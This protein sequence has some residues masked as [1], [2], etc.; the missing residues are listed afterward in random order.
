MTFGLIGEIL[1]DTGHLVGL[2]IDY[3]YWQARASGLSEGDIRAALTVVSGLY[4]CLALSLVLPEARVPSTSAAAMAFLLPRIEAAG[5]WIGRQGW[6]HAMK[7]GILFTMACLCVFALITAL[8]LHS[9]EPTPIPTIYQ[10]AKEHEDRI[11]KLEAVVAELAAQQKRFIG[12]GEGVF[13]V[14]KWIAVIV[15][16]TFLG[17]NVKEFHQT[18]RAGYRERIRE[19][20][21]R[22]READEDEAD[23]EGAEAD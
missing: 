16:G 17:L 10:I 23:S 1:T 18:L 3:S 5:L 15:I 12:Y 2:G 20:N 8:T 9:Q 13:N 4:A 6:A 11:D 14:V 7:L 21:R 19:A 22:R